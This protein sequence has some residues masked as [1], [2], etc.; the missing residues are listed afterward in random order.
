MVLIARRFFQYRLKREG[1][2]KPTL[3]QSY[4]DEKISKPPELDGSS[5]MKVYPLD[6]H[7]MACCYPI[8]CLED[9]AGMDM[10][11]D[12]C[13]VAHKQ[14]RL[15]LAETYRRSSRKRSTLRREV[16]LPW[17]ARLASESALDSWR[18]T[19]AIVSRFR[20]GDQQGR[21]IAGS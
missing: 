18:E 14:A 3:L 7:L 15:E 2:K 19:C 6:I 13:T 8:D 12:L 20:S 21:P 4:S 1:K 11:S 5:T 17:T 10:L 16:A 9:S